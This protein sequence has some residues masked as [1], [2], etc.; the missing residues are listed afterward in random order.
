[1][2]PKGGA[3]PLPYGSI[4]VV[5]S[6]L[7]GTLY[8]GAYEEEPKAERRGLLKNM[9]QVAALQALGIPVIPATGNNVGFAQKKLLVPGSDR[10][11]QDLRVSPGIYCNGALVKGVGG[12]EIDAR[13]LTAFVPR[14]VDAWVAAPPAEVAGVC[15]GGLAKEHVVLLQPPT[16]GAGLET[17]RQFTS[18]MM[19]AE[20]EY[21]WLPPDAFKA[22]AGSILSLLMLCPLDCGE[23]DLLRLQQWLQR[24]GLLHFDD[25][26]GK[27]ASG[28]GDGVV[29]KH[30]HVPGLGPEID[31]SPVG[32]N[33]GSAIA[34]MLSDTEQH[35]GV[36]CHGSHQIAVF[37]D[38]GND[39]ELFGM[40][41]DRTGAA[42]EPLGLDF[43]PAIRVAM[44]WANDALLLEDANVVATMD[45]VL[46]DIAAHCA[47]PAPVA[48][49]AG[50][51]DAGVIAGNST[52]SSPK[53]A[54]PKC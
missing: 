51:G 2:P 12:K 3:G 8:P 30:V 23:G 7:D 42:L 47:K 35:L 26:G 24:C 52:A 36:A 22:E 1:M 48:G 38:A 41:R 27:K 5:F 13:P 16:P 10:K 19:I 31:I 44:P 37:G 29:C 14:F 33:K 4:R 54:E 9:E 15:I 39:I 28:E 45:V 32:V 20:G 34:K 49:D 17:G 53:A 50:E 43:R 6:D 46:R 25:A 21:Q 18:L 40:K 11:L